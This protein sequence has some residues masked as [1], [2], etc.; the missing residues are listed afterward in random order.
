[1]RIVSPAR[2]G[3]A[4]RWLAAGVLATALMLMSLGIGVAGVNQSGIE[5]VEPALA[6]AGQ[7][8]GPASAPDAG[9]IAGDDY[10]KLR[11][12]ARMEELAGATGRVQTGGSGTDVLTGS[13]GDDTLLGRA[14]ADELVGRAGRDLIRGGKGADTIRGGRGADAISGDAGR[15]TIIGGPGNDIIRGGD[16]GD[17]IDSGRG[18]DTVFAGAGN[19][20]V[21][22]WR[23]GLADHIDC[24][25]GDRDRAIV[26]RSDSTRRCEV[27]IVRGAS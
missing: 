23:D 17:I 6:S 20:I 21:R 22:S 13:D 2:D 25:P 12:N 19:D 11:A 7:H 1:M 5:R 18:K 14:G 8:E 15:D 10:L 4:P 26:D 9:V 24:G 3:Q 16:Q 27:V